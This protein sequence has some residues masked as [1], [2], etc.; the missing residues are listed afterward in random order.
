MS[1][2]MLWGISKKHLVTQAFFKY[3]SLY[4]YITFYKYVGFFL[5]YILHCNL[6]K[7]SSRSDQVVFAR[8][9]FLCQ[10]SQIPQNTMPLLS[11]LFKILNMLNPLVLLSSDNLS[12]F[13]PRS[14]NNLLC[15]MCLGSLYH[16]L[17]LHC[18]QVWST[19]DWCSDLPGNK[20]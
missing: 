9:I 14:Q 4:N 2:E 19:K 15:G 1:V 7:A 10:L 8:G 20:F 11:K 18:E 17:L 3:H 5:S 16:C 6:S 13:Q 12:N